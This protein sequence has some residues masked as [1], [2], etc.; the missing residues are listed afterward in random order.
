MLIH[1][2]DQDYEFDFDEVEVGQ[3]DQIKRKYGITLL[4]IERGLLDVDS[5][6]LRCMYWLMLAQNGKRVNIDTLQ[7]KPVKLAK[8]INDAM[9]K[10]NEKA[11]AAEDPKPETAE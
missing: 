4:G 5:E 8:A 1:F 3:A 10:E 9:L 11:A 7:F 2:D 6:A